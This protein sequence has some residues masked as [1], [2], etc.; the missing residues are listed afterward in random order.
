MDQ[1]REG[2]RE[3]EASEEDIKAAFIIHGRG[4][5]APPTPTRTSLHFFFS[6]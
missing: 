5:L 4:T 2:G 6:T 1:R 3:S